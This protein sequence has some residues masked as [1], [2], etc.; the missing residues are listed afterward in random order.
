MKTKQ[1]ILKAFASAALAIGAFATAEAQTNLGAS[2]GC[3]AVGTRPEVIVT[4][5]PGYTAISGTYGGELTTGATFT[6]DKTY[7]LDKKI[8]I[9]SG[10]VLSIQPGTV[11]K[12]AANAV[13]AEATALVIERGGKLNAAGTESCPIVFT[14]YAD[15]MDGTYPVYNVGKW[16]GLVILG[17]ASNNLTLAAN[18]PYVPGGAG[19]LAVA[20][21]LGTIEGFATSNTQD[22]YGA[23]LT[24]GETFN[25]DDNSGVLKYVSIRHSG[26]ILAVG[27]E[28]NGLTLGS[29]GRGTTIEHIEIVSCADDNIEAF[30]GTVNLKYVSTLFGND[31][32]FDFDLGYSG[33]VQ[34]FFG[35]KNTSNNDLGT[36]ASP[37]NDNGIE[38]DSDDN[39][40]N[41]L[42][43]S[44]PVL[45]NFTIIGNGKTAGTSDNRGVAGAN[46]KD[47]AEGELYNSIFANFK[48]GITLNK[49]QAA[50]RTFEAYQN[51]TNDVASQDPDATVNSLK[52]KCNTFV[53]TTNPFVTNGSNIG[54]NGTAATTAENAQFITTDLNEVI[55]VGTALPGF[56]YSFAISTTNSVSD[57]N[58]V[59]PNPALSVSGCPTVPYNGFFETA[60][61]R[62]AFSS[63]NGE[64]WLSNWSYSQVLNSTSGVRSCATDLN[65]DGVTNV[66]DFL[67]FAPAFGT[68][69]N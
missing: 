8:Y 58:D 35:M 12:G 14:A 48:N 22:Q 54:G 23:N 3:P 32:M 62:G 17:R 64:N 60:N 49:T 4:S 44:H 57:K 27:A 56:D 16:G 24:A 1:T 25:D 52:I 61:Y 66:S 2:C 65:L 15:P 7:I 36:P 37:D 18:G 9:P 59:T 51:W 42:P 69:C 47:G 50:G 43:K 45:Y 29:V 13:P 63:V 39:V 20:N 26:A 10:Q 46:F 34:F 33:N 11:I 68:S 67:I 40:S 31:D 5:L 6:C 55:P 19:K 28:I 53:Q 41:N 21:G 30:G 38:G